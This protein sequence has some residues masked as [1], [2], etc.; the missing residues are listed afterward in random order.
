ME[1]K[2]G[3]IV[4]ATFVTVPVQRNSRE[5]NALIKAGAVPI[6]WGKNPHKLAQKETDARW[7]KKSGTSFYGFKDHIN[8]DRDTKLITAWEA[9]PAQVHDSRILEDVLR[10]PAEG[11]AEIHAD[12]AYRR[13]EQEAS[14]IEGACQPYL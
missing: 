1:L 13:A 10:S 2:S 6:E 4:D 7:T 14:L 3:Q 5:E 12:S 11:G 9:T 8:V